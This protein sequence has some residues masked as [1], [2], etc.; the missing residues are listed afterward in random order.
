MISFW[1][2]EMII[3][4]FNLLNASVVPF[5]VQFLRAFKFLV[6]ILSIIIAFC[7]TKNF[8]VLNHVPVMFY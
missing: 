6:S 3:L 4:C 7:V 8:K 1:I 2:D 5:V